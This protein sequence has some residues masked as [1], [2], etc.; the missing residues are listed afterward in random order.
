MAFV[1]RDP[2]RRDEL[3]VF[4]RKVFVVVGVGLLL[5][6]LWAARGVLLL[7]VIA[8]V[9]AAGIAPAV[10]RVRVVGRHLLRRNI[11]RGGAVLIVYLPFVALLLTL[12]IVVVP[13]MIVEMRSLGAQLPALIDHN[14]LTPLER[15]VPMG[16]ARAYI[17]EHGVALPRASVVVYVRSAV[18][19]V[20]SF[21]AVLF[22]VVYMLIDAHRLRNT[23]LLLYPPDVRA[24]RRITLNRIARRMSSWL[25]AQMILSGM[26][27]VAVFITLL[28]LRVPFALPLAMFATVG[29]MVPVIGPILGTTPALILALLHS[30]WQFWTLL[31][32][33]LVYQKIE[34]LFMGPRV[35]SKKVAISPLTAFV[36]F[37]I[38]AT[39]FGIVGALMAIPVAAVLHV[40]FEEVFVARR[41]RRQDLLRAGTLRKRPW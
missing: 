34:N 1:P 3:G 16:G 19:A 21:I 28:L 9:L 30:R 40:G 18:A 27:G 6:L 41:E 38:G 31:I 36:A 10:H 20:G 4:T 37:M 7:V 22:M 24:S 25:A 23:I 5:A 32:V 15:F 29:E 12:L 14:I 2:L 35:M 8:A 13:R 17:R 39:V 26:I 11:P 33:V